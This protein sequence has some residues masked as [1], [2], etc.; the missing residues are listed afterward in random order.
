MHD[1]LKRRCLYHWV[2]HPDFDREVAIVAGR[3]PAGARE[4]WPARSPAPSSRSGSSS[5]YKPPGVAETIDWA[6]ALAALGRADLDEADGRRHPRHRRSSTGRTRSGSAEA[7]ICRPRSGRRPARVPEPAEAPVARPGRR[8]RGRLR[9]AVLRR[10][11]PGRAGRPRAGLRRALAE[12]GL[13]RPDARLLGRPGDAGPPARGH[14]AST[15]GPSPRSSGCE[16]TERP[17]PPAPVPTVAVPSPRRTTTARTTATTTAP[18]RTGPPTS[19]AGQPVEVLRHKDFAACTDDGA[20]RGGARCWP[21]RVRR[22]QRRPA[23]VAAHGARPAA[24][25]ARPAPHGTRA[26]MRAGGEPI[27]RR[28][29]GPRRPGR[30]RLVLLVDVSGSMEA[31][32]PGPAALRP[33]RGRR[34]ARPVEAFA[35]GTRLTRLTRELATR[36]PDAALRRAASERRGRLVRRHPARRLPARVQRP[37]GASGAWP[38]GPTSSSSPTGGTGATPRCWPSRW[39]ACTG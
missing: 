35:L 24:G 21:A 37:S 29:A 1:A 3:G 28:C 36:D 11:R 30:R 13:R 27:D 4:R 32:R 5:L 12:A 22:A 2:E 19:C 39:R 38:A 18:T 33:R 23:A 16:P 20:G 17:E 6:K 9:A 34:P 26:A 31:L 14:R 7:G 15:T 10:G 25:S 8:D